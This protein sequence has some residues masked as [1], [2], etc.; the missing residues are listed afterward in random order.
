MKYCPICSERYDEEIIRFCTKDGTPLIDE[1]QPI[2]TALPSENLDEPDDDFGQETI[3]RRN[4]VSVAEDTI[5]YDSLGQSE[6]IV[7][8]TSP[9]PEQHVR[10]RTTQAYYPPPPQSNTARTVVLTILGTLVVFGLG[11]GIFWLL[12]K[13]S[14]ANL[15]VNLNTNMPNQNTNLNTNLGFDSNFNFNTNSNLNTNLNIGTNLNTNTNVNARTPSPPP[16]PRPSP[17][18]TPAP[19]VSPTPSSSP[20]PRPTAN[21]R[22]AGNVGP[23][24]LGTPRMGPRPPVITNRPPGNGN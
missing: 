8:P 11:A 6:R 13:E 7:I 16:S 22:P 5:A 4:P 24:P 12:Q 18:T 9:G 14:P 17:S 15:N 10:P 1:E 19:T 23:S 3:I 2:F 21:T 20:S